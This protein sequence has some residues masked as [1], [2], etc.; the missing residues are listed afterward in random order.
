MT[1]WKDEP[2]IDIRQWNKAAFSS[3]P[4]K[5][6]VSLPLKRWK[7]LTY[8]VEGIE[9]AL[10]E[11]DD[12]RYHL[13]GNV[14]ASVSRD[15]PDCVDLR[16]WFVPQDTVKLTPTRRGINLK[17]YEWKELKASRKGVEE[18]HPEVK[19]MV[20]CFLEDDHNGQTLLDCP[21]CTPN[22]SAAW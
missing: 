15:Y 2:R 1:S 20:P 5:K 17:Y 8:F 22:A 7:A 3:Y 16:Q 6:G 13:G 11:N 19:Q 4:S 9:T 18:E 21:E 14:F 10:K 12:V